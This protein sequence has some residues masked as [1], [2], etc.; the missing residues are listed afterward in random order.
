MKNI[1]SFKKFNEVLDPQVSELFWQSKLLGTLGYLASFGLSYL[2]FKYMRGE[3]EKKSLEMAKQTSSE[4]RNSDEMRNVLIKVIGDEK[5]Q[6]L[7]SSYKDK[8]ENRTITFNE[9]KTLAEEMKNLLGDILTVDEWTFC[10]SIVD[11]LVNQPIDDVDSISDYYT[12]KEKEILKSYNF[13]EK[14]DKEFINKELRIEFWIQT[15][16]L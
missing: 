3:S 7:L 1:K 11:R 6:S 4:V 12:E 10:D 9:M 14:S 15:F 5:I 8:I 16:F 2:L 13:E